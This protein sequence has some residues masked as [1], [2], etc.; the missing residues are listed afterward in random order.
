VTLHF[1]DCA[2]FA[3]LKKGKIYLKNKILYHSVKEKIAGVAFV[4]GF[5]GAHFDSIPSGFS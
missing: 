5:A 2:L 3:V 4:H 1:A